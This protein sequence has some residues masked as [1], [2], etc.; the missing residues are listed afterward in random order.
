[1]TLE[2]ARARE[3]VVVKEVLTAIRKFEAETGLIVE[4]F[5]YDRPC[6]GHPSESTVRV[7]SVL[8]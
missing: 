8:Q 7:K 5:V 1:M 4:A 2:E 6:P 3:G